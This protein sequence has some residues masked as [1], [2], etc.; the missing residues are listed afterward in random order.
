[1]IPVDAAHSFSSDSVQRHL[2][3]AQGPAGVAAGTDGRTS[4]SFRGD[5]TSRKIIEERLVHGHEH[6]ANAW[7]HRHT[8]LKQ[9]TGVALHLCPAGCNG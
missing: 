4:Q 3:C 1:M 7:Q 6:G 8:L 9:D 2:S 5:C